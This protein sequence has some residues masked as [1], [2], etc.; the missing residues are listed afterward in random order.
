MPFLA[1]DAAR[2]AYD[3]PSS[4]CYRA[5]RNIEIAERAALRAAVGPRRAPTPI[6]ASFAARRRRQ[7]RADPSGS[8]W[9]FFFGWSIGA[10]KLRRR[11]REGAGARR[12]MDRD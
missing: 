2:S 9:V 11:S 4:S 5:T 1:A 3:A 6:G 7:G 12:G 10:A 8:W